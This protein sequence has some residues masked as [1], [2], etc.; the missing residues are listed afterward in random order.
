ML[1]ILTQTS[2]IPSSSASLHHK[3][4]I[5][6]I[7]FSPLWSSKKWEVKRRH[8][9][10]PPSQSSIEPPARGTT[11]SLS[12]FAGQSDTAG[13]RWTLP[14]LFLKDQRKHSTR[15]LWFWIQWPVVLSYSEFPQQHFC[16]VNLF[17]LCCT[18]TR[19]RL[20]SG[21]TQGWY[22]MLW[23][24]PQKRKAASVFYAARRKSC[25]IKMLPT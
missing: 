1:I 4:F 11:C 15:P 7:Q 25:G 23:Q 13:A 20:R 18:T 17:F 10:S 12:K 5:H 9:A 6:R 16:R 24:A 22:L 3:H 2:P 8:S 14:F 19:I 21:L